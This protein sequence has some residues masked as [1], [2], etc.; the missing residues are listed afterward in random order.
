MNR[1]ALGT[2]AIF[3]ALLALALQVGIPPKAAP[4]AEEPAA[5]SPATMVWIAPDPVYVDSTALAYTSGLGGP[6]D[7]PL[8]FQWL[9]NGE[10]IVRETTYRLG[11]WNFRR[12][13]RVR[14]QVIASGGPLA[15]RSFAS[16]EVVVANRPPFLTR[17][18]LEPYPMAT[19]ADT[20]RVVATGKDPDGDVV[21]YRS[22]WLR[23]GQ[24]IPG[25]QGDTLP[26]AGLIRGDLI[27]VRVVATDG[28]AESAVVES[29]AIRIVNSGPRFTSIPS[30]SVVGETVVS[31]VQAQHPDGDSVTYSLAADAPQGVRIDPRTGV[32]TWTVPPWDQGGLNFTVVA[33]DPSGATA[34]ARLSFGYHHVEV[35]DDSPD[36]APA[37]SSIIGR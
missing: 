16:E 37:T 34:T 33:T 36:A 28:I 25:A 12:G 11:P 24:P 8:Q 17:I 5:E 14:V 6:D 3:A 4:N 31:R 22:Q 19:V 30:A 7:G 9:R 1:V 26:A 35:L 29:P 32:L 18:H 2:A 23:N 15:G 10:V 27:S 21:S 20:L 13:D